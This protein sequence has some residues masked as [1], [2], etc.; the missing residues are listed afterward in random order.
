MGALAWVQQAAAHAGTLLLA[1]GL[2]ASLRGIALAGGVL[3]WM[4]FALFA[5]RLWPALWP[6]ATA[7]PSDAL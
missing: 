7:V 1:G 3:A 6:R 5:A 2:V 4:A